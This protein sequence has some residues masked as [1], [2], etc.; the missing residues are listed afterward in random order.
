[1]YT[2]GMPVH[3]GEKFLETLQELIGECRLNDIPVIYVQH[4]G[5]KD[6]P[7]EKVQMAGRSMWKLHHKKGTVSLK[8]DPRF[9][10]QD[11]PKRSIARQGNRSCYHFRNA[12]GVLCGYDNAKSV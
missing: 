10:P 7:L 8:N 3:N 2:A 12:N 9:I 11:E 1:M 4:N 6:H 5:P